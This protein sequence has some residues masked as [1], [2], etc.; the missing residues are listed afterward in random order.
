MDVYTCFCE[1]LV[2]SMIKEVGEHRITTDYNL[3]RLS[4]MA[5]ILDIVSTVS[6]KLNLEESNE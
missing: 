5:E 4:Q 1:T 2:K 6:Y 3:D